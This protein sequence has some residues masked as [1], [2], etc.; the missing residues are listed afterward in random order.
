MAKSFTHALVGLMVKKG[1]MKIDAPADV[2]Q[3]KSDGRAKITIDNLMHM[4]S[5]L[6]WNEDYGNISNVNVMLHEAIDMG[7]FAAG[8]PLAA[9]PDSLW[10]YSSGTTNIVTSLIR[11]CIGNDA[12][13]YAFPRRELFNPIGM[14]SAVFE[15]D[16]SGTFAGSSYIY[17]SMRDYVRFGLLYLNKGKWLGNQL[18]PE[19]WTDY[20]AKPANGSG[21]KYG[22][23]FW[24]N[25][26]GEFAGVPKDLYMCKGHDGQFIFIVPSLQ[27]VVVRTGF[28]KK[29]DFDDRSWLAQINI[30]ISSISKKIL[31]S[32]NQ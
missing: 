10:L 16:A 14:R 31:L 8:K 25:K 4:N 29:G 17:A 7:A 6:K 26:S 24:L 32:N 19:G 28:S 1:L 15:V 23:F 20:A 12:E 18:L 3:W 21:G 30:K 27:L 9:H 22:A 13:Y 11:K 5:G 2:P